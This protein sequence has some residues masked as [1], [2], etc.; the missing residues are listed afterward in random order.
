MKLTA[1]VILLFTYSFFSRAQTLSKAPLTSDAPLT[2]ESLSESAVKPKYP[3]LAELKF[4]IPS[5]EYLLSVDEGRSQLQAKEKRIQYVPSATTSIGARVSYRGFGFSGKTEVFVDG[6]EHVEKYGSADFKDFRF[7]FTHGWWTHAILYQDYK[8][9]YADLNSTSGYTIDT[10]DN[11]GGPV[12][13]DDY[14]YD[15]N[16]QGE[17]IIKRPDLEAQNVGISTT[18]QIPLIDPQRNDALVE[19][20]FGS[21]AGFHIL[22]GAYYNQSSFKGDQP[23]IPAVHNAQF[24][25]ITNL[26]EVA[27]STLGL[28]LGLL[29]NIYLTEASTVYFG[30]AGGGGLQRLSTRYSLT[31]QKEWATSG[32]FKFNMGYAYKGKVHRFDLSFASEIWSTEIEDTHFDVNSYNFIASYGILL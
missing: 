26:E 8:G 16:D 1:L 6:S 14:D 20:L 23:L 22:A 5:V 10:G 17:N 30:G 31:E 15:S 11:N 27:Y 25:S 3:I 13:N 4:E 24:G 9:F 2:N 18:I 19:P 29:V 7:D 21:I 32:R 12:N 28:D